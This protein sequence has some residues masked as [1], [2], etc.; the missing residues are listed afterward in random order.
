M[1]ASLHTATLATRHVRPGRTRAVGS[2]IRLLRA[3]TDAHSTYRQRQT[4]AN[5]DDSALS[6]IGLTREAALT[7]AQKPLWDVPHHWKR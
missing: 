6:D 7:E 4:L 3:A 1:F 5:L 2:L